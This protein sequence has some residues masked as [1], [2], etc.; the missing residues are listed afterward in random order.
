MK[1]E[2][3]RDLAL[4]ALT[5]LTRDPGFSSSILDR[6]FRANPNL[7]DRDRAFVSQLVQGVVRWR[8]RLDWIIG[9]AAHFPLRKIDPPVLDILRLALYQIFFLNR[10]P[11]SAAVNEA[12]K[13]AKA[14]CPRHVVSFVNGLLR[15]IC[16]HKDRITF[17]DRSADP[18]LYLSVYHSY[19]G[20]LVE[21]WI[22]ELGEEKADAL[23]EAGNRTPLLTARVNG[24][25]TSRSSLIRRMEAEGL[26]ARPT[27]Y[28][29]LGVVMEG[30]RGRVD[31]LEAFREGLLQVQDEAAQVASFLLAPPPGSRVLDVCAGYGGKTSH[32]AEL[33]GNQGKV[34]A[35]DTNRARLISLAENSKR[36][37]IDITHP[38]VADA[39]RHVSDLLRS[40]FDRIMVDAPCS[41]LGVLSRHPDGKWNRDKED[42]KRLA[43]LQS[44]IL[45]QAA[46]AL[47]R[48]GRML[49]VTCTV[50]R[51]ENEGVVEAFLSKNKGF[52]L[53]NLKNQ[54][55]PWALDLIDERGFLRALPH[56][57]GTDGFFAAL[58]ARR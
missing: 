9:E 5:R 31:Q 47:G 29:P 20:W 32:L 27:R 49:Y 8:L 17:P 58:F 11:E 54:A 48:R 50:S 46:G 1:A 7:D 34:V 16:R 51:D 4:G 41:G 3:P 28:S 45:N 6:L 26:K 36:L 25:K 53:E 33:M 10:I 57:H 19:P 42:V 56:L 21:K 39:A 35:L 44:S 43:G 14:R 40:S 23:L 22:R 52:V 37:G 55:P 38:V 12:V 24:L 18:V 15:N 13:Q 30:L 2:T